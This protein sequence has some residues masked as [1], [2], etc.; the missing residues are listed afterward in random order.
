MDERSSRKDRELARAALKGLT[1][2]GEQIVRQGKADEVQQIRR[3]IDEISGYWGV[4]ARRDWTGEFDERIREVS[5]KGNIPQHCSNL[6]Q[7]KAVKGLY[8]YAEE[9]AEV[10]GVEEIERILEIPDII[11]RMGQAW[12]MSENEI[13]GVCH[14]I[15]DIAEGLQAEPQDMGMGFGQ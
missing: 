14:S 2:Y 8:R 13:N 6:I 15:E 10:Q 11:R 12:E 4:D 7:L 1:V 3:I 9:M 5:Q